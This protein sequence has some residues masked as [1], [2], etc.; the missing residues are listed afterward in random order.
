MS[1][2]ISIRVMRLEDY[3]AVEAFLAQHFFKEEPLMLTPQEDQDAA[4]VIPAESELHLSLIPQGL[5]LVAIDEA[6][7]NRIVGV[8][9][10]GAQK[11]AD[12]EQ[13]FAEAQQ[14]EPTCLL[15][16]IHKF[17]SGI[18]KSANYFE[19]YGVET[20]LYLYILGVDSSV[21]RQGLG[22]R[23]VSALIDLGRQQGFPAMVSTCTNQNSTRL[24]SALQMECIHSQ[25][26][27]D[28]KDDQGRV[29][30]RPPAPHT[31]GSVMGIRL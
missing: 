7:G 9:L 6:H 18:E 27:A 20:A 15:H 24:M 21:R 28:Y 5:S 10:A 23:L 22:S 1:A 26:Y 2:L 19:H 4:A 13:H 11:P 17:L 31:T 12:V 25:I 3:N 30:L 29:V 16:H 8:I 14:L